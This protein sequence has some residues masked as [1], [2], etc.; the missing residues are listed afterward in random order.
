MPWTMRIM[1]RRQHAW[2]AKMTA[3]LSYRDPLN[4]QGE[5]RKQLRYAQGEA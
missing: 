5:A 2:H 3:A 4:R 1:H